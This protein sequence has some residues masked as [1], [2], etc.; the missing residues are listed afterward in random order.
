MIIEYFCEDCNIVALHDFQKSINDDVLTTITVCK[1]CG[2][3]TID[4]GPIEY[5]EDL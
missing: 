4:C 5:E 1:K 3:A 2:K